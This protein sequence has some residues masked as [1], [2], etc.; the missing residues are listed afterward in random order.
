MPLYVDIIKSPNPIPQSMR[1][2][3][4]SR[5]RLIA[6]PYGV[7][8]I[9]ETCIP[10]RSTPPPVKQTLIPTKTYTKLNLQ[11]QTP[12]TVPAVTPTT[13]LVITPT[14]SANAVRQAL[15][16]NDLRGAAL[17]LLWPPNVAPTMRLISKESA[18]HVIETL[19]YLGNDSGVTADMMSKLKYTL[20][21]V[22]LHDMVPSSVYNAIRAFYKKDE[23]NT[24]DGLDSVIPKGYFELVNEVD[25]PNRASLSILDL[26]V[27]AASVD[28]K[29]VKVGSMLC[30]MSDADQQEVIQDLG[31]AIDAVKMNSKLDKYIDLKTLPSNSASMPDWLKERVPNGT[32]TWINLQEPMFMQQAP[33]M[34]DNGTFVNSD[35][36]KTPVSKPVFSIKPTVEPTTSLAPVKTET[37][38]PTTWLGALSGGLGTAQVKTETSKPTTWW[39]ALS[40]GL[41]T[42]I[43]TKEP[44]T[45]LDA[46][47]S[48]RSTAETTMDVYKP[49]TSLDAGLSG[50]STAETTM[51]VYKPTSQWTSFGAFKTDPYA[52]NRG[53][54]QPYGSG[55]VY[56]GATTDQEKATIP[57]AGPSAAGATNVN[58]QI[59]SFTARI[60]TNDGTSDENKSVVPIWGS[61]GFN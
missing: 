9:T 60:Q 53:W 6:N 23:D 3:H 33:P 25:Y 34:G 13:A 48:G 58:D 16:D 22:P 40:G 41:G 37:S 56:I 11:Q 7:W 19:K 52:P 59:F 51:E 20:L 21:F 50:L 18:N 61:S 28:G 32:E 57:W 42:P 49:T 24:I 44:T 14:E 17:A 47:L 26:L 1:D 38:K 10:T 12:T 54:S 43:V 45:S 27:R 4:W 30:D 31:K 39:G 55:Q 5:G 15:D 8:F 29:V 2:F 35:G 46:G 36:H